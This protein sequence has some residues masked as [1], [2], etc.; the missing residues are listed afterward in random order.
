M[1]A[2]KPRTIAHDASVRTLTYLCD[3]Q[4]VWTDGQ[5]RPLPGEGVA[6]STHR[7]RVTFTSSLY[8]HYM[9]SVLVLLIYALAVARLTTIIT[10]DE[11]SRPVR[12]ALVRRFDPTKRLHR[13]IVYLLG[14][15]EDGTASGCPWCVSIWIGLLS[16]PL[17]WAAPTSPCLLVPLMGLAASQVTGMIFRIGR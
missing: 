11:I 13:W 2:K 3:L 10:T 4:N 16:A 15:A 14:D 7:D 5:R 8:D 6:V 12:Q 17:V 9:P 1:A